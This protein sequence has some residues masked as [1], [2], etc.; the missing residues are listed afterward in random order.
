MGDW[1]FLV[2]TLT[3]FLFGFVA[4]KNA[5]FWNSV[6]KALLAAI[7]LTFVLGG[8]L[9]AAY[10]N[11]FA[12][13]SDP[14]LLT[15]FLLLKVFY[16]WSVMITMF[17]L[18]RQFANRSSAVL[19]YLT[20]AI[21]PYYILHQTITLLVSYW[22]T[23]HEAPLIVEATTIVLVTVLGCVLGYEVIRR[24]PALRPLFG[25]PTRHKAN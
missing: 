19:T 16:G 2:R 4:A 18:A 14:Q 5:D 13:T 20:A 3:F 9:L 25:L 6:D 1:A 11:E 8:L 23:V 15:G 22:F 10:L 12:V 7:V 21:F 24:V 17:G